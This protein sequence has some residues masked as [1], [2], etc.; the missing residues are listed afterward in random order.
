MNAATHRLCADGS[1]EGSGHRTMH[2]DVAGMLPLCIFIS[3]PSRRECRAASPH[4][5][6]NRVNISAVN[7]E[8]FPD[9]QSLLHVSL[10][11]R[12]RRSSVGLSGQCRAQIV[13][14]GLHRL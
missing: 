6:F 2:D 8:S 1:A 3:R 5:G 4:E 9:D 7:L 13:D 11:D 10:L 14:G 12:R